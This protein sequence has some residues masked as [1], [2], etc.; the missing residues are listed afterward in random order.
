[1]NYGGEDLENGRLWLRVAV[2]LQA[3]VRERGLSLRSRLYA[4]SVCNPAPLQLQYATCGTIY[5]CYVSDIAVLVFILG[6]NC[7]KTHQFLVAYVT[8]KQPT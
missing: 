5:R 4:G 2:W 1:M 3:K 6:Q 8:H 7:L